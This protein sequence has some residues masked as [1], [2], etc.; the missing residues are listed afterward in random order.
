MCADGGVGP[1]QR[2]QP[3]MIQ[4]RVVSAKSLTVAHKEKLPILEVRLLNTGLLNAGLN[5][6]KIHNSTEGCSGVACSEDKVD[7]MNLEYVRLDP[8]QGK[9]KNASVNTNVLKIIPYQPK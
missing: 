4:D 6:L 8:L 9:F 7:K 2:K 1:R 5:F 3:L